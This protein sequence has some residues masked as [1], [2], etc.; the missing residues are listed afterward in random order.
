[1]GKM[2]WVLMGGQEVSS[3]KFQHVVLE[4]PHLA[5]DLSSHS[6]RFHFSQNPDQKTSGKLDLSQTSRTHTRSPDGDLPQFLPN[7]FATMGTI[8]IH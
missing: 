1:M 2:E 7:R 6:G 8:Y 4:G 5:A 3:D